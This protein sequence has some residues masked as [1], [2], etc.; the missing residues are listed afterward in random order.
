MSHA[1]HANAALTPRA[2]LRLARVVVDDGWPIPRA[3]ERFE[4]AWR[5]AEKWADRYRDEAPAGAMRCGRPEPSAVQTRGRAAGTTSAV[6]HR[7]QTWR[8]CM[9]S[10]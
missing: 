10:A 3:A 1:S 6:S 2:R 9:A 5:T 7:G 4:V 8:P